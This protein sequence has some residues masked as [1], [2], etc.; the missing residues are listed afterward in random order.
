VFTV[1]LIG[2]AG[3]I[4][5]YCGKDGPAS[6]G[7]AP[8]AGAVRRR[9]LTEAENAALRGLY[10]SAHLFEGGHIGADYSGADLPFELLV[11]RPVRT[12]G[13]AVALVVSGNSTFGRG[14]RKALLD[15]L[16]RERSKLLDAA[17][18]KD[19]SQ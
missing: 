11:V 13:R 5:R 4:S 12:S 15:W 10:A 1:D 9:S 14:P 6:I 17:T 16:L 19:R 7:A 18:A 8:S 2:D 3:T